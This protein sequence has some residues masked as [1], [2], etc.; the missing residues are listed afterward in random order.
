M[1]IRLLFA[2]IG[3]FTTL[4]AACLLPVSADSTTTAGTAGGRW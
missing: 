2:T 1:D 3:I 4:I